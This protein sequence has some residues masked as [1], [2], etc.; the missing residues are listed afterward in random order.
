MTGNFLKETQHKNYIVCPIY[1]MLH[2]GVNIFLS[3]ENIEEIINFLKLNLNL[4][5]LKL[6]AVKLAS[7]C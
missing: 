4:N 5:L 6:F 3:T 2:L 7:A 1:R